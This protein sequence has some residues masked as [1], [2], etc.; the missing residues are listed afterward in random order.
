MK[1]R[2]LVLIVAAIVVI[3]YFSQSYTFLNPREGV[4]SVSGNANFTS[5]TD[6]LVGLNA[7][8]NVTVD[9]SGVA[10]ITASSLHDLF[11]AQGYYSA[12]NR[13]FQMEL[14]ALL[15]SG[16]LSSYIGKSGLASDQAMHLIGLPQNAMTLEKHYQADYPAY[17]SYLQAY[18]SGVDAYI[19]NTRNPLPLG[20]K[21]L[22]ITPFQWTVYDTLVWQ[23]YMALSLTTGI[24][25]PLQSALLY[26]A[27]GFNNTTQLWPYYPYY[28]ENI[29]NVPGDGTV[30][31]YNLSS[32]GI[33]PASLW[34][35]NWYDQ[36][37]TGVNATL[38]KKL[39]PLLNDAIANISDPYGFTG[40]HGL[41]SAVG[42]N[43]WVV[44]SNYSQSG[45]PILANDPHL[46]LYAPSL[47]IPMQL[48][49]GS[50]NV[51]G[52][53]L[54]G[55]PGILIGHTP[56]TSW[57][58]TT[59]EGNSAN[60]YLEM[61][62][63]TSYYYN[64]TWNQ[65]EVYN[66]SLM[67]KQ[68]SVYSTNNGPL[69]ARDG[70]YG[71]S[72]MWTSAQPSYDLV[73]EILMDESHN[74]SNMVNAL[75]NWGSPPQNF[76]MVS[77]TS[78]GILTAGKYPIINETLPNGSH[79]DVVGSRTLLN[80]STN[81]YDPVGVVPFSYLPQSV[82]PKR[83][84]MFAPN[85]PTAGKNYPY[86][87][88][89]GFWASG[90]RAE[91]IYHFLKDHP[92]MTVQKMMD[93]QSNV[94]DYWA[95]QLAPMLLSSLSGMQMNS[96]EQSAFSYLQGWNYT[97]YQS[98]I[99]ITVYWYTVSAIY[100]ITFSH[101]Y[102]Q[103]N[104]SSLRLPFESSLIFLA[105]NEPNSWWFSTSGNTAAQGNFTSIVRQAFASAVSL[106]NS[107]LGSPTQWRWG[108]VHRLVISSQ[109]GLSSLSIGPI[110]IWGDDHTVSV[111]SVPL[112][113]VVPEPHVSV[114]SSL[115]EVSSPG[116]GIFYGVFPGGP[117][118][119]P[120]SY[121]FSNQLD[122][123]LSHSYYKMTAQQTEVRIRYAP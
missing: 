107:S 40:P 87:F 39:T 35:L 101:E 16:N 122:H 115:R 6:D 43:S 108:S 50:M 4:W 22:G 65:M 17:Y 69:I 109:T 88:I 112:E 76:A 95:S 29:T 49:S 71:I 37:A 68:Y 114:G 110:P 41:G 89:G 99:G 26:N 78:A 73:A 1:L 74:Y 82:N 9:S 32:Q 97:T 19:N 38:L 14:Q 20:F 24:M 105:K 111:G 123:W 51:T 61:V 55:V 25:E 93:L 11:M 59:S 10:H 46:S 44:T 106:L 2:W 81:K 52:W 53:D 113:M 60:D 34:G 48:V 23:Q 57:G 31:G 36:W 85:Q 92:G 63:G 102:A 33:S 54:A 67:G 30:N 7:P 18:A 120:L 64:G 58:L 21:L 119:N 62:N 96:T 15:A 3:S 5:S 86:P 47:W 13:L 116:L 42:S 84:Y 12:S 66:Y 90:G 45:D 121:Y 70:N 72:M 94:S 98:Q 56:F 100:N 80:G 75:R 83:G 117:S 8:V 91:T 79:V 27:F 104:I 28:T 103:R 77:G 118:E